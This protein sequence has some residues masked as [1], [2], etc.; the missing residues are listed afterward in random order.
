[1]VLRKS[2]FS[3]QYLAIIFGVV[4]ALVALELSLRLFP[5]VIS[6]Q[7]TIFDT[8][9]FDSDL[10]YKF[11]ELNVTIK[12]ADNVEYILRTTKIR[13]INI[14]DNFSDGD[15]F[16]VA[17]GDSFTLGDV[18]KSLLSIE[19]SLLNLKNTT[20]GLNCKP[21]FSSIM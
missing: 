13:G 4:L 18:V 12:N 21:Y 8:V 19:S 9:G 7:L 1:M 10:G 3:R 5:S 6:K 11:R 17:V 16:A 2:K 15:A 20:L 14:R